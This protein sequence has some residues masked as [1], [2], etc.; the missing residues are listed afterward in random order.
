MVAQFLLVNVTIN[1]YMSVMWP[2]QSVVL[3]NFP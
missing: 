2:I 3:K 1:I